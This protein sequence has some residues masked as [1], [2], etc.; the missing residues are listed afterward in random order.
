MAAQQ[1]QIG[2]VFTNSDALV[3][4]AGGSQ[5]LNGT[6]PIAM[7]APGLGDD[8]FLLD[9]ATSQVAYSK[10][11]KLLRNHLP[12]APEWMVYPTNR[13]ATPENESITLKPRRI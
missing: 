5:P 6:N 2:I 11:L 8:M 3:A 4:P 13:D 7:A 12:I 1:N 10:I 9:M